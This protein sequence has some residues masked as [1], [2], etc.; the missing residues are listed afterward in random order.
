MKSQ[1]LVINFEEDETQILQTGKTLK[2]FNIEHETE[3]SFFVLQE[4]LDYKKNPEVKW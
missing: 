1:H 2:E 4:Y 3:L